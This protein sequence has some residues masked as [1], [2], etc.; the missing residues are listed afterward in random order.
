[1]YRCVTTDDLGLVLYSVDR[2]TWGFSFHVPK[3]VGRDELYVVCD[4]LI[5]DHSDSKAHC[6]RSCLHQSVVHPTTA[7]V[8]RRRLVQPGDDTTTMDDGKGGQFA[9]LTRGALDGGV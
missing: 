8:R 2:L 7:P 3:F 9:K 4:A 6:D 1:V 5:C